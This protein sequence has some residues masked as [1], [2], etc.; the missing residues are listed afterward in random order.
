MG[1]SLLFFIISK[2]IEVQHDAI[3]STSRY[4]YVRDFYSAFLRFF[5]Q[6][7]FFNLERNFSYVYSPYMAKIL[8]SNV[9][10][11]RLYKSNGSLMQ[12][13]TSFKILTFKRRTSRSCSRSIS[14]L[15]SEE[16]VTVRLYLCIIIIS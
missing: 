1:K 16:K 10:P 3:Q 7:C 9:F 12:N 4:K 13:N 5:E 14:Y 8:F 2:R 15:Q 6:C 11:Q